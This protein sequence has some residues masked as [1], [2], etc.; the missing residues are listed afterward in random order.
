MLYFDHAA[1]TPLA[2][3]VLAAMLGVLKI[4]LGKTAYLWSTKSYFIFIGM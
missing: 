2:P 1:T 4:V 3:E